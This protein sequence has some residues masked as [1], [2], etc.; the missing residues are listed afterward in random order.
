MP[1]LFYNL[2][3]ELHDVEFLP[4]VLRLA[5]FQ[6]LDAGDD[7][8]PEKQVGQELDH[9]VDEVIVHKVFTDLLLRPAPVHDTGKADDGGCTVGGQPRKCVHDKSEV[10]LGFRRQHPSGR[11]AGALLRIRSSSPAHLM[12]YGGLETISSK[13]SS[14][15]CWGAVRVSSQAMSKFI[16]TRI[17]EEHVDIAAGS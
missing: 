1:P 6:H 11:K 4:G 16:K 7:S 15:Q 10:D 13:G 14:S 17:V 2:G 3:V 12:E 9:I 8:G 5:S